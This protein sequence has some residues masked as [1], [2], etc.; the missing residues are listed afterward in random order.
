M[1]K[2]FLLATQSGPRN[3]AVGCGALTSG[4]TSSRIWFITLFCSGGIKRA[5][6]GVPRIY[7]KAGGAEKRCACVRT[8]GPATGDPNDKSNQGRS[9]R[10]L[11]LEAGSL[12]E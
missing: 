4:M 1:I 8:T 5:W 3:M 11:L 9:G 10:W 7:H 2:V 6:A 12:F